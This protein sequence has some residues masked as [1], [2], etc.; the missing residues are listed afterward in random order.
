MI[1][2]TLYN[3]ASLFF[4]VKGASGVI[5]V[6]ALVAESLVS[7]GHEFPVTI[8]ISPV[9]FIF[10]GISCWVLASFTKAAAE[11]EEGL[12]MSESRSFGIGLSLLGLFFL[13]NNLPELVE[14]YVQYKEFINIGLI[15]ESMAGPVSKL[16][17]LGAKSFFGLIL[18]FLSLNAKAAIYAVRKLGA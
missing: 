9:L 3:I 7:T 10:A 17:V 11:A 12:P 13:G 4:L 1:S 16:W 14:S 5:Q 6:Q 18:L 8:Y 15:G 2:K